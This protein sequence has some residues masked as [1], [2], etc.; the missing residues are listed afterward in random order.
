MTRRDGQTTFHANE[1]D[2][3]VKEPRP[4]LSRAS[5]STPA[6]ADPIATSPIAP[7]ASST[8][9]AA[10]TRSDTR[11]LT[12]PILSPVRTVALALALTAIIA[13][14][15][16]AIVSAVGVLGSHLVRSGM[17]T[18]SR[19]TSIPSIIAVVIG[20]SVVI[21]ACVCALVNYSFVS[22]LRRMTAA[23]SELARG[24]FDVRIHNTARCSVRE[25][26]EFV[27]SFN[28]AA[29]ELDSTEMMRSSFI[30]DFSHEFRTPINALSGFAQLLRDDDG[31]LTPEERREYLNII[32]EE[33]ERLAGLSERILLL[34]KMEAMSI[35]PDVT[36]VNVTETIRR[37]AALEEI[38]AA[39]R[40][41]HINLAL[42][43]CT[44]NGNE[45]FLV[46]LW[47]NLLNNAIKFSPDGGRVDV[48]L[49]GGRTGEEGRPNTG[50]ELVCWVS[51]EGCGMDAE[52]RAHLFDR[53]YQGDTS[54]ASEG[55]GLGLA[56]CR[57]I[58]ELHGGS[59]SVE[60]APSKGSTFEV[61]LPL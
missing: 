8:D 21:A 18:N 40:G 25:V 55:S 46:Q 60:S 51:D 39:E 61:R 35:L 4:K 26:N 50:D 57:R 2:A 28:A 56:L 1:N 11:T 17:V 53:F 34:S 44:C 41:I 45:G 12:D 43:P 48:A 49:Y 3:D 58:V 33:S 42:D 37:A 23:I 52:T 31:S 29:R 15:I 20:G 47:T 10:S 32:V 22:P 7:G 38:R 19:L 27:S 9:T 30:S 5:A 59:I 6:T 24:N 16:I 36:R 54:H 13:A 14:I